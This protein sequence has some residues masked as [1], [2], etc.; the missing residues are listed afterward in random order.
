NR[1]ALVVGIHNYLI[2]NTTLAGATNQPS[3]YPL[4]ADRLAQTLMI[5]RQHVTLLSD[6]IPNQPARPVR[7]VLLDVFADF[8][9][10]ARAQ[11][12]LFLYFTGHIVEIG[13][14]AEVFLV[15][16]EGEPEVV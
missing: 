16:L 10:S 9:G 7:P 6:A 14:P 12:C 3:R 2:F 8:A 1:R 13:E 5:P 15:P 11:D 4:L